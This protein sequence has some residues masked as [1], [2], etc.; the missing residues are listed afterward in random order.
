MAYKPGLERSIAL[1]NLTG[2]PHQSYQTIHVAGTNGKGSVSH[3]LAAVLREAK[4][5][6]GLYTSP[7]L[8]DF[9]ERIRVNGKKI[10]EQ[11]VIDF[12]DRYRVKIES[13]KPSFFEL[14]SSMAFEFFRHK[15]VDVAIIETGLGGRLDCTN[16][17][18]PL[19]S[20][21]TNISKDHTQFL[22]DTL[23]QIAHEKAG[24]I[25]PH[26]PVVI[27]EADHPDVSEIFLD[28]ACTMRAPI[29]F[30]SE[31]QKLLHAKQRQN[32]KWDFYLPEYGHV[33]G[34]LSGMV[35][36]KNAQTVFTVLQQLKEMRFKLP[37]RAVRTA[38]EKVVELTGLMGRWQ[39]LR[40]EPLVICDTG[41]NPG[42]WESLTQQLQQQAKSRSYLRI[43]IGVMND[44]DIDSMLS[45]MP[46][47]A[48]YYFTQA[49]VG[50]ALSART[51]S[52]KAR[53]YGLLGARYDT[54]TEAVS[55]A[56]KEAL[57]NDMI[58]IGGSSFV[59][60]DALPLFQDG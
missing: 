29:F 47:K 60:A 9:R 24:I 56:L 23:E 52:E 42:A 27:G 59:I 30:A 25:K 11:Y 4:Y 39:T 5:K 22:G 3:L 2:H 20:V 46:G 51:L 53:Q 45:L 57:P 43:I 37:P 12:V 35:Q 44:K 48:L 31:E 55:T 14:T 58:F 32:G 40:T 38:F 17:I 16:I 18:T 33:T 10:P 13:L 41:H 36:K 8:V 15:K 26:V 6:V 19:L 34:E 50:R 7:H 21:I 49:S 1:D 54:V 28:R